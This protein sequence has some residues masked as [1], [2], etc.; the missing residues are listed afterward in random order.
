MHQW[1]HTHTHMAT[2]SSSSISCYSVQI[3]VSLSLDR[4]LC[5]N[6]Y[7]W[8]LVVA[9]VEKKRNV[10]IV[11]SYDMCSREEEEKKLIISKITWLKWYLSLSDAHI[12]YCC[13]CST[14]TCYFFYFSSTQIIFVDSHTC[15]VS[16]HRNILTDL[17]LNLTAMLPCRRYLVTH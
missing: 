1:L 2:A 6:M 3:A 15:I 16:C 13:C 12:R 14:C 5:I 8:P 17:S 11:T 9:V 4:F 10:H 7:Q